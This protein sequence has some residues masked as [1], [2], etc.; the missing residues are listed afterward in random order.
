MPEKYKNEENI[1]LDD[2]CLPTM[3]S[4]EICGS[5]VEDALERR[6][7]EPEVTAL[8]PLATET[9]EEESATSRKE[10]KNCKPKIR[11]RDFGNGD[12]EV[13]KEKNRKLSADLVEHAVVT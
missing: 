2:S 13:F 12:E 11:K 7:V 3:L 5:L 6:A 8:Q 1:P 10:K 9:R 4:I